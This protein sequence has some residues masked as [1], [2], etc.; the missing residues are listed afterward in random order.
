M[1]RTHLV[2][3]DNEPADWEQI[4]Y[5]KRVHQNAP[6][7]TKHGLFDCT[8]EAEASLRDAINAFDS[9]PTVDS[10]GRLSWTLGDNTSR[11][12]TRQELSEALDDLIVQRATRNAWLHA[13]AQAFRHS[14]SRPTPKALSSLETWMSVVK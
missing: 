5:W 11:G 2:N 10:T 4:R 1:K 3:P 8:A 6:V 7:D 14:K 13:A 9:L 12:F